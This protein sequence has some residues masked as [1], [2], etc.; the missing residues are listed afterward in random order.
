MLLLDDVLSAVD[1]ATESFIVESLRKNCSSQ[2]MVIV[3]HRYSTL[4]HC[5]EILYL[6][7]GRILERGTHAELLSLN[8]EYARSW[9]LQSEDPAS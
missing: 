4:L 7:E 1:L 6:K 8:G 5:D 3:S 9:K 2:T